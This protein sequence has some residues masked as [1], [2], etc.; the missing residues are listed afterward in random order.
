ML[1]ALL[2]GISLGIV[3]S[4]HCAGMCGPLVAA[5][6]SV[7]RPAEQSRLAWGVYGYQAGRIGMYMLLGALFGLFGTSIQLLGGQIGAA[8]FGGILL[9]IFG[10]VGKTLERRVVAT[11]WLS[12]GFARISL[13]AGTSAPFFFGALNGLLPCGLIYTALAASLALGGVE[14]GIFF[15]LGFGLATS[16]A[17]MASA[18]LSRKLKTWSPSTSTLLAS[19]LF[20]AL[21]VAAGLLLIWRAFGAELPDDWMTYLALHPQLECHQ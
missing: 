11:A 10:L 3:G 5:C 6:M 1:T 14:N 8:L 20:P 21:S 18:W 12:K 9:V 2:G 4:L 15:M 13:H 16:P 17:L 19:R 7:G